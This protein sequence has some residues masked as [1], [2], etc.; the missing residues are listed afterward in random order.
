MD[1]DQST[2]KTK[3]P[4]LTVFVGGVTNS[5]KSSFIRDLLNDI[6]KVQSDPEVA[7]RLMD[8][9]GEGF[10]IKAGAVHVGKE[11]RKLF[12]PEH[13]QGK[14]AMKETEETALQL[15]AKGMEE[16]SGCD[17]VAVDGQP[18]MKSQIPLVMD[19]S[20]GPTLSRFY[21]FLTC[22]DEELV[23]RLE[24]RDDSL[25]ARELSEKRLVNDRV[26]LYD[27]ITELICR[28]EYVTCVDS[29]NP[30]EIAMVI[31]SIVARVMAS[32]LA[33]NIEE[34]EGLQEG[35]ADIAA[36]HIVGEALQK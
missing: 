25:M 27:V 5:G 10:Y 8:A 4:L 28:R 2:P 15:Y 20:K 33:R 13:F 35:A 3:G 34:A 29:T 26:Q 6:D 9:F 7:D 16:N 36:D 11:M 31:R 32:K 1:T 18:R 21:V 14:G 30:A 22:P 17:V 23:R 12:P 24:Q 19:L